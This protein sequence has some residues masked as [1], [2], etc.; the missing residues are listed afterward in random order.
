MPIGLLAVIGPS[1]KEN[2]R[3]PRFWSTR[4]E[5]I[6]SRSQ[7]CS[8]AVATAKK[9]S[10]PGVVNMLASPCLVYSD[11][12]SGE[13]FRDCTPLLRNETAARNPDGRR[14]RGN[15]VPTVSSDSSPCLCVA[16]HVA[17]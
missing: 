13:G 11:L 3:P 8:V 1:R 14:I 10:G 6:C 9:S 16:A 2:R 5:K 15:D 4:R 7:N 17:D 12:G